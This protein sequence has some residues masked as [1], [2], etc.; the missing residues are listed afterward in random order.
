MKRKFAAFSIIIALFVLLALTACSNGYTQTIKEIDE[1]IR[2]GRFEKA[3]EIVEDLKKQTN[4]RDL[5]EAL[6]QK[7]NLAISAENFKKGNI[8]LENGDLEGALEAFKNVIEVDSENYSSALQ[9]IGEINE[10]LFA[11]YV[12]LAKEYYSDD[13]VELAVETLQKALQIRDS[14]PVRELIE[15]YRKKSER[16][17]NTRTAVKDLQEAIRKMQSYEKGTGQL[18]ISLDNIY[19]K[20]FLVGNNSIKTS[21]DSVFLKL[22]INIINDG[23]SY[24]LVKPEYIKLITENSRE[25][26][27]H[28]EYTKLLDIPLGEVQLPPKGRASGRLMFVLPL[29]SSYKFEYN[30]SK[31]A[32]VKTVIPY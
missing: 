23:D 1:L 3:L 31:N 4:D 28:P 32:I 14:Q 9:K 24:C 5:I 10:L 18:K 16:Q 20:E 30:D 19:S 25:F 29:E 13:K 21:G 27:Y 6:E 11:K 17:S 8:L 7:I 15:F 12:N 2:V 22:W 26:T